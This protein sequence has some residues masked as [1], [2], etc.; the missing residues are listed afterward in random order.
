ML[1]RAML[2]RPPSIEVWRPLGER[3][4]L[5]AAVLVVAMP[6]LVASSL[7]NSPRILRFGV[8]YNMSFI[9]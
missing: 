2:S 9:R 7:L 4:R 1:R 5:R 3:A 6:W 8:P